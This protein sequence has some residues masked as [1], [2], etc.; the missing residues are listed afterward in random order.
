MLSFY[1]PSKQLRPIKATTPYLGNYALSGQLRP[2]G[3]ITPYNIITR[4]PY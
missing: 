3:A 2:T 1:A 4:N